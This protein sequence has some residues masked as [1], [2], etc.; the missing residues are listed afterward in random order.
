MP[1]LHDLPAAPTRLIGRKKEVTAA[2]QALVREDLHLLS[3]TGPPG[4]GKTRLA[5]EVAG[6]LAREFADGVFFVDLAPVSDPA[7][8]PAAIAAT[9]GVGEALDQ[10]LLGHLTDH[11]LGKALLL[12]LD[13]FE[14]LLGASAV[15]AEL[16]SKCPKLKI[17][18]TS[19]ERLH[20]TWE[21][22]FPVPPLSLPDLR[23]LPASDAL[24]DYP[25]VALF[26]ERARAVKPDFV[27]TPQNARAV[28]EVCARL[29]GL[30]LAIE[31][32]AAR[33]KLLPPLAMLVRLESRLSFLTGG[34]LDSVIRHQTLRTAI[35]WSYSLLQSGEQAL[36]RRLS[37]FIGG[38]S[39]EA[40][41]AVCLSDG[42]PATDVIEV[43]NS[44]LDQSLIL[45]AD[46]S[47][48]EAR[49][50]L[51][52]TIREFGLEQ[53]GAR[54]ERAEMHRHA[55][56]FLGMAEGAN[57]KLRS[58]EQEVWL[59]R[60]AADRDNLR[61]ALSGL[62]ERGEWEL[63]LRL[64]AALGWFWSVRGYFRDGRRFLEQA[65]AKSNGIS[66]SVRAKA[67]LTLGDLISK[68]GDRPA[69]Q[70]FYAAGLAISRDLLDK[71]GIAWAQRGL[72]NIAYHGTD[73]ARACPLYE[74]SL[75]LSRKLGDK[76]GVASCL[77]GL[78]LVA[79]LEGDY[80]L[81]RTLLA[82]GFALVQEIGDKWGIASAHDQLVD[83]ALAQG[84]SG[85]ARGHVE[86]SLAL[87][88]A[89]DYQWGIALSLTRLGDTALDQGDHGEARLRYEEALAIAR[90]LG[91]KGPHAHALLGLGHLALDQGDYLAAGP[92]LEEALALRREMGHKRALRTLTRELGR[93]ARY[94]RDYARAAAFLEES[95]ALSRAIGQK[96]Q[97]WGIA[98]ALSELG[99]VLQCLGESAKAEAHYKESLL[100]RRDLG[101]TRGIAESLERLA[102]LKCTNDRAEPA[103]RLLG[104]AESLREGVSAPLPVPERPLYE[105]TVA[106]LRSKLGDRVFDAARAKGRSI[107]LERILAL[108]LEGGEKASA[109]MRLAPLT[110][111]EQEVARLVARGL[112][113]HDIATA[114]VIT[115]GTAENHVQSILG[116]LE[117]HSRAQI[118]AWVVEHTSREPVR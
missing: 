32:A 53:L 69:A 88:R 60:L 65:L 107:S 99:M 86:Q 89:L 92:L 112:S 21:N 13:N 81:S 54:G 9:L 103:A 37:V 75:A 4:V 91:A 19:R 28:A 116:K 33:I 68:Q 50:R 25:G 48:G 73:Y 78:A 22:E 17:L 58:A 49:F 114:L 57:A 3:L 31:L 79:M 70:S 110:P 43:L 94:Q 115:A 63:A 74:E 24:S 51:L 64:A 83:L 80:V 6:N 29:D 5:L 46:D 44:L 104:A 14:H 7:M 66:G 62:A 12:V 56:Y 27:L 10:P 101:D 67:L 96:G 15:V 8:V 47:D 108:V 61:T 77:E 72:G 39:A 52:E 2:Q 71:A 40:A 82:E 111:R 90:P 84:D 34:P 18:V 41:K 105:R 93:L 35:G 87:W 109:G 45:Q 36:F 26:V 16:L 118:A 30:P 20:L 76:A 85:A 55:T 95:L 106:A 59:K 113:N 11:L 38:W 97:N 98:A 100:L 1:H 23:S 42:D 102:A 117:F